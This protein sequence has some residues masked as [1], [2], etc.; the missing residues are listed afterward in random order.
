MTC[1]E[2]SGVDVSAAYANHDFMARN[3]QGQI[4][5]L[6]WKTASSATTLDFH[7]TYMFNRVYM[8]QDGQL[9]VH[10]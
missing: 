5:N 7:I 6:F 10:D 8:F 4:F 2:F 3:F 1:L 9:S